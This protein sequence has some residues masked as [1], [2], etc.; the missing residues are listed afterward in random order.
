[1]L[2]LQPCADKGVHTRTEAKHLIQVK[3][4]LRL[5]WVPAKSTHTGNR[6]E[7][8]GASF[9]MTDRTMLRSQPQRI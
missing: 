5:V 1:M 6:T 9:D 2:E 8:L 4:V 7:K 3:K